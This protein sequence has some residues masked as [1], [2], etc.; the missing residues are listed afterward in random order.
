MPDVDGFEVLQWMLDQRAPSRIPIVVLTSSESPEH[1][2][3]SHD[4]G[5]LAFYRKPAKLD[6]LDDVV[7][8][9]VEKWIDPGVNAPLRSAG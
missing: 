3:R 9:I 1:E 2:Q 5:A 7:R 6:E 4:L 8:G